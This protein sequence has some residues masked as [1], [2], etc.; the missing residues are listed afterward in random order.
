M[1]FVPVTIATTEYRRTVRTVVGDRTKLL[2]SVGIILVALGPM[3]AVG[4]LLLPVAGEM[5]AAGP[6]EP[7][8][9]FTIAD[10]V[11]GGVALAW[12]G[13]VAFA[14]IRV[15]ST[16]ANLDEPALVLTATP[17][18]TLV[19]GLV[20]SELL[21][22]GT[23]LLPISLLLSGAF[24][25]GTGT[26]WPI[27]VAPATVA[28]L[29]LSAFPVGFALGVGIRHL[30]TVY[31]P[32]ARYRTAIFV[33]VG[34]AYFGSIALGWFDQ[35]TGVLFDLLDGTPLGWPG[36]LLLAG[37]PNVT[38]SMPHAVAGVV[39]SGALAVLAIVVG[40]RLAAVHWRSDPF[41]ED[42][43]EPVAEHAGESRLATLLE[44]GL[45]QPV[46]TVA[47]TALRRTKRA[48][49]R[50]LYVAYPLF[51]A[52][53]FVQEIARAG[54][55]PSSVAVL[56]CLYVVWGAGAFV[57][58]NPLGDLGPALPAVL[59][60]TVSGRQVVAGRLVASALVAVPVAVVVSL[61]VGLVSPLS[62][63]RV[64]LLVPATVVGAL[65][66]PALAV[67][68]GSLFP[69]FGSVTISSNREAVMPSK[70][71]FVAYTLAL[72]IPI[73][74]FGIIY[75]DAADAV[76]AVATALVAVAPVVEL[77]VPSAAVL[78]LAW[79]ALL[80]GLAGPALSAGYAV[81]TFDGYVR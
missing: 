26:I 6:V 13:L 7:I 61:G 18:R 34:A 47:V 35:V 80:G 45:S 67:G 65:A 62:L 23:W 64:A 8:A 56:T 24:A 25:Y 42:E 41:R 43:D 3:M 48:P 44:P 77:T 53:F 9:G 46:R 22:F 39:G 28:V 33:L 49:I 15:V 2:L 11:T 32:I 14:T 30:I 50:L 60:S 38:F 73:G 71:A 21:A 63:E 78:A 40:T 66:A 68:I 81:R 58:L 10:I 17:I 54:T 37:L 76:A 69:R 4:L 55:I 5:L 36:H 1:G 70:S 59:T 57:S 79:I 75:T 31:E 72:A 51:M 20:G 16:V 19:V 74:A 27:L 52:A 12:V 29:F